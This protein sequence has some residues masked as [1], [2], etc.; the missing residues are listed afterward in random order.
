LDSSSSASLSPASRTLA[1]SRTGSRP[2]PSPCS[3]PQPKRTPKPRHDDRR[4]ISAARSHHAPSWPLPSAA[5]RRHAPPCA[6]IDR[7]A[8]LCAAIRC[9]PPPCATAS[10]VLCRHAPLPSATA[11]PTAAAAVLGHHHPRIPN[12]LSPRDRWRATAADGGG[13]CEADREA[14]ANS[15][16]SAKGCALEQGIGIKRLHEFHIH[17]VIGSPPTAHLRHF[18]LHHFAIASPTT[19]TLRDRFD[20][21]FRPSVIIATVAAAVVAT[22]CPRNFSGFTDRMG[23]QPG[24][25]HHF[26]GGL[27]R[28]AGSVAAREWR[29]PP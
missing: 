6:A 17:A 9:Y 5:I 25:K 15:E 28:P 23:A 14:R 27:R 18:H 11:S 29:A 10:T 8:P 16:P 22:A 24:A 4:P 21:S 12:G 1:R 20:C 2:D 7:D 13:E 3:P 19:Q 26:R